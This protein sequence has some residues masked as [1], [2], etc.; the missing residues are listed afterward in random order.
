MRRRAFL[1]LILALMALPLLYAK[2]K[3]EADTTETITGTLAKQ[4]VKGR[5]DLWKVGDLFLVGLDE[6][7]QKLEGK[8]VK[9][10][11][12][13]ITRTCHHCERHRTRI[14]HQQKVFGAYEDC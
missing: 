8:K 4:T 2:E 3:Q 1:T 13:V 10:T 7:G 11:G 12:K 6:E 9:A 14:A 5:G